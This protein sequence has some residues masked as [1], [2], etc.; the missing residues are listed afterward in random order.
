MP[1]PDQRESSCTIFSPSSRTDALF[2]SQVRVLHRL[3]VRW[4]LHGFPPLPPDSSSTKG[5]FEGRQRRATALEDGVQDARSTP[6]A[7]EDPLHDHPLCLLVSFR[8]LASFRASLADSLVSDSFFYGGVFS[9]Y[10]SL[11]FSVRARALSA[12]ITPLSCILS[13]A[14]YGILLDWRR[15]SQKTRGYYGFA[16]WAVPQ[17]RPSPPRRLHSLTTVHFVLTGCLHDL[18][19]SRNEVV[20][21][22]CFN[23]S[24]GLVCSTLGGSVPPLPHRAVHRLLVRL[25]LRSL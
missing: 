24:T 14:V 7:Q 18:A 22:A 19:W 15:F 23:S 2:T 10:L 6:R 9:T 12:F 20:R 11:H 4:S 1:S 5:R 8:S 3:R 16:L 17:V 21:R 25:L 13:T